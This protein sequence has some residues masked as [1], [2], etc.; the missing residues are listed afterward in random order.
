MAIAAVRK[1]APTTAKTTLLP[2]RAPAQ[3]TSQGSSKKNNS[4]P[5]RPQLAPPAVR[6][7][8]PVS[9]SAVSNFPEAVRKV[10]I[11]PGPGNELPAQVQ[12]TSENSLQ[13]SLSPVRV[14]NDA[15][16]NAAVGSMGVRAFTHGVHIFLGS[17][18][19]SADVALMMHEAAHVI[20]QQAG[21]ALRAKQA[22][23]SSG[24]FEIE[25]D[26]ASAAAGRGESF[27]VAGRTAGPAIQCKGQSKSLWDR[28]TEWLSAT[29]GSVIEFGESVGWSLLNRFAPELVPIIRQG[30]L[31]WLKERVSTALEAV[32]NSMMAPVRSIMGAGRWLSSQFAPLIA[33]VQ[34]AAAKIAQNDCSPMREAAEKIE[35]F[36]LKLITPVVEKLQAIAGK[37]KGWFTGLWDKFGAP[38]W[39]WIKQFAGA[40]WEQLKNLA[41]MIWEKAAPI[42]ESVARAWTWIKNKLGIGEGAEGQN[43]ILQWVQ[44]KLS[45]AWDWIKAKLEPFKKELLVVAGVVG[46]I[47]L[48]A[49]PAGPLIVIGGIV[50]GVLQG[51]RWIKANFGK[52]DGVVRARAY[53]EKTLIPSLLGGLNKATAAVTR[54]ATSIN[55]TLG[56]FAAGMGRL[57]SSAAASM[58]SF[59]VSAVQWIANQ[60]T[61]LAQ[62]GSEKLAAL[63]KWVTT[64]FAKLQQRLQPLLNFLGKV[65]E[66]VVDIMKLPML[67]VGELW[68]RIPQCLRNLFVDFLV[69][70]ILKRIPIVKDVIELLPGIW[71]KLKATGLMLI[72]KVFKDGDLMGAA[73]EIFKLILAALNIPLELVTGIISKAAAAR[74]MILKDPLGFLGNMLQ[75]IKQGFIQFGKKIWAHLAD[76]IV[77]WLR[78]VIES[79]G[80]KP[81]ADFSLSSVLEFILQ[82]LGLSVEKILERLEKKLGK[83]TAVKIRKALSTMAKIWE[84][85]STAL[86]E[87]PQGVWNNLKQRLGDLWGVLLDGA[88]GWV[89]GKVTKIAIPRI[90]AA[91]GTAPIGAVVEAI[92][93]LYK[94]I[95]TAAQYAKRILELVSSVLNGVIDIASGAIASAANIVE[96]SLGRALTVVI[97]FFAN[98][99]GLGDLGKKLK[100]IVESIQENVTKAID[101]VI[102]KAIALGKGII[103]AI[104][105]VAKGVMQWWKV[106]K[107]VV[108]TNG[109]KHT[110]LM[111]GEGA[112]AKLIIKSDPTPYRTFVNN[113]KTQ[114]DKNPSLKLADKVDEA[115][116][117]AAKP[118]APAG[119]GEMVEKSLADLAEATVPLLSSAKNKSTPPVF[120]PRV[121]GFGSSA[122]VL[123]LTDKH[124]KGGEPTVDDGAYWKFLRQRLDGKGTYYVR[125]HLLNH[126]LGGPG[127]TWD[128]LTPLTQFANNRANDSMLKTF[129]KPI[130]DATENGEAINFAVTANYGRSHPLASKVA[131]YKESENSDVTLV[132]NI[133]DAE[134]YVPVSLNCKGSKIDANG[135]ISS[136]VAHVTIENVIQDRFADYFLTREK[137]ELFAINGASAGDLQRLYGIDKATATAIASKGPYSSFDEVM[138]AGKLTDK[139]L[140]AARETPRLRV[141]LDA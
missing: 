110:I 27:A 134:K 108:G 53:L 71:S 26:S 137:K 42:R 135:K 66:V 106:S 64:A 60:V 74:D 131:K 51:I 70:Q 46:S 50:F 62:W 45:V 32:F 86:N 84:W 96:A 73:F 39:N 127:N 81:P 28:G 107:P 82:V 37:V 65:G 133:I 123:K 52:G 120:G 43:G 97:G 47:A 105:K 103:N 33:W 72:R 91:L 38:V 36:A 95:Q 25:A 104:T 76:S 79:A 8:A 116:A 35:Q 109:E 121:G 20:Q 88:I 132:G 56:G 41:S 21:P 125:G 9:P 59:V 77:N 4:S 118:N 54:M 17:N 141:V 112:G 115:I 12:Q 48:L 130:K 7:G 24:T 3:K 128:N 67:V 126:N 5:V 18:E 94:A 61:E 55:G 114:K 69:N 140:K 87:G 122:T 138:K 90:T 83:D 113:L 124:E 111:K 98:Y 31:E 99:L 40:Q 14:H 101:W 68:K 30:P 129:E 93:F 19:S 80:L 11:S 89:T 34:E 49:S 44:E 100:E 139:E 78:G 119:A 117:A 1:P 75:A 57:V 58:L 102:H 16:A 23:T 15:R 2:A 92:I 29:A 63:S 13:I 10:V 85:I 136:V 6:L 22:G